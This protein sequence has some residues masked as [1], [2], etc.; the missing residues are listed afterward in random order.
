MSMMARLPPNALVNPDDFMMP[1]TV[2]RFIPPT[3]PS[4]NWLFTPRWFFSEND[5]VSMIESGWAR[6]ISGSSIAA[7]S[8]LS[9]L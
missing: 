9:R 3:V 4:A 5:R 1:R 8:P 6:K 2:N 7:S